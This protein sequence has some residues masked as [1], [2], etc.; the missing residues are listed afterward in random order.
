MTYLNKRN[1]VQKAASLAR[2]DR[3]LDLFEI[4]EKQKTITTKKLIKYLDKLG[5]DLKLDAILL[6]EIVETEDLSKR[7]GY[8]D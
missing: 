8:H 6:R 7:P 1:L 3:L 5:D 2:G 4:C